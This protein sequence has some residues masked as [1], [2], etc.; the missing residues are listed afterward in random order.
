MLLDVSLYFHCLS[1]IYNEPTIPNTYA[2]VVL[3]TILLC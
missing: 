3:G 2:R 1:Y